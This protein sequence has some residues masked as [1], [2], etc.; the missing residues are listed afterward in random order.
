VLSAD[1]ATLGFVQSI[2]DNCIRVTSGC[3]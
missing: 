1:P 3:L 2:F